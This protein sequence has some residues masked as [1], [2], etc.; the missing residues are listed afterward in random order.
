MK[1]GAIVTGP[2]ETKHFPFADY[3][4][5]YR[6]VDAQADKSMKVFIDL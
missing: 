5:A 1:A 3:L 4:E 6:Y 2:L